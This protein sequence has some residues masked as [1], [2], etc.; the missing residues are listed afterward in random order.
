MEHLFHTYGIKKIYGN[1]ETSKIPVDNFKNQV[2][3]ILEWNVPSESLELEIVNPKKQSI[4]F[5]L[6]NDSNKNLS[7]AELFI[8]G[9]LLGDWKFNLSN[10]K[11]NIFKG[12]L[13]VTV[14][15]DWLSTKKEKPEKKLFLFNE[16]KKGYY[17]LFNINL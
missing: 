15:K 4:K 13:K 10:S 14:Y 9:N 17:K 2:R 1:F 7:I 5:P 6:G 16:T 12:N 11:K 8:N 3:I